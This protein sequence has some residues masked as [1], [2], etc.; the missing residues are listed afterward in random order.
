MPSAGAAKKKFTFYPGV[1]NIPQGLV[2]HIFGTSYAIEADLVVPS[3]GVEGVI[4][5][6]A[7]FLGGFA[8]YVQG[9]KLHHHYAFLGLPPTPQGRQHPLLAKFLE[10][11]GNLAPVFRNYTLSSQDR[12]PTGPVTVRFEF[13]ADTPKQGTG[14]ATSL[15]IN[16]KSV[17]TGRLEHTVP[18]VFTAYAC[19]DIGR[20]NEKPVSLTYKSPF[21]FTGT[22]KEVRF[23]LQPSTD[24]ENAEREKER[25]QTRLLAGVHG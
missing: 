22:I 1:Q 8:L 10:K 3:G 17:A 24:S 21:P 11:T 5:A 6:N 12:L 14:G 4:V 20:D 9:G 15:L 7:D 13:V 16:G 2:P 25:Q 18:A 23:E 19:M